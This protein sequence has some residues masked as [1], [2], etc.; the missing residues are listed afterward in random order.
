MMVIKDHDVTIWGQGPF[1]QEEAQC[2]SGL[3][4]W[5]LFPT[6]LLSSFEQ[7]KEATM[8]CELSR[9]RA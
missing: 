5:V 8:E 9:S 7:G 2:Y 6:L 4:C 1:S 3:F